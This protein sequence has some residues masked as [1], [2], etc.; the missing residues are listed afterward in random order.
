M[1]AVASTSASAVAAAPVSSAS[2]AGSVS[3]PTVPGADKVVDQN[4]WRFR[5]C[6]NRALQADRDA[7]G[8]VIVKVSIDAE[9]RVTDAHAEPSGAEPASLGSCV[10]GTFYS[11]RFPAP[12]GGH[13][14]FTVKAVFAAKK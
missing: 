14:T 13:A 4:K 9:G 2:A 6:Y 10:A 7:G 11:M 5:G 3:A 8:T 12:D 1:R